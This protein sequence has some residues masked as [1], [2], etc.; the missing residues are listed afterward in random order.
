MGEIT[1]NAREGPGTISCHRDGHD[2]YHPDCD[3]HPPP[4]IGQGEEMMGRK[5]VKGE[6]EEEDLA[7]D[8]AKMKGWSD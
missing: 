6:M 7:M 3:I 5:V 1:E 2:T 8:A 4:A